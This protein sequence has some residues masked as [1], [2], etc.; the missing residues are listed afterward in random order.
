MLEAGVSILDCD[1]AVAT[2]SYPNI[3]Y[4][5]AVADVDNVDV[6]AIRTPGPWWPSGSGL[7]RR[8]LGAIQN[9]AKYAGKFVP[10]IHQAC[11]LAVPACSGYRSSLTVMVNNSHESHKVNMTGYRPNCQ[12]F[13][14]IL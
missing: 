3:P 10:K 13:V 12:R 7:N 9:A 4:I 11:C 2:A 5:T 8:D 14:Y 6:I 1:V